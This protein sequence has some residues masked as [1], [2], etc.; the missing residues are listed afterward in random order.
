MNKSKINSR[1]FR[2]LTF[3][4][5][6]MEDLRPGNIISILPATETDQMINAHPETLYR[7]SEKSQQ[8]LK[9]GLDQIEV[10]R[11]SLTT[12]CNDKVRLELCDI[13]RSRM[14]K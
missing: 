2:L 14:K 10:E 5:V 9:D 1:K 7:V 11:V 13:I 8:M 12:R 4:E 6:E 3:I